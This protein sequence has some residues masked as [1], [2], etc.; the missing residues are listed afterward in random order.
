MSPSYYLCWRVCSASCPLSSL[1]NLETQYSGDVF[2]DM[3]FI[4]SFFAYLPFLF[5]WWCR[6]HANMYLF[7]GSHTHE[8]F[9]FILFEYLKFPYTIVYII[10]R[11]VHSYGPLI[12]MGW[13]GLEEG[14][15]DKSF[16]FFFF[17]CVHTGSQERGH[18]LLSNCISTWRW[19]TVIS[20]NFRDFNAK[21]VT[22]VILTVLTNSWFHC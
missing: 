1:L 3:W 17:S 9:F 11:D 8:C 4:N 6:W 20:W 22:W 14:S 13:F 10:E 16:S 15:W 2:L 7:R 5:F 18:S 12:R 21:D 19:E